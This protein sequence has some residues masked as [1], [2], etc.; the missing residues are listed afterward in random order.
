MQNSED[1]RSDSE[2]TGD[3]EKENLSGSYYD[4]SYY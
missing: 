3:F 4:S 1:T 2:D